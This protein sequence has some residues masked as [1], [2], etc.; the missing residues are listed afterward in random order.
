MDLKL[1][2]M[3]IKEKETSRQMQTNDVANTKAQIRYDGVVKIR[4]CVRIVRR[5]HRGS[6]RE[7]FGAYTCN[8]NK[9]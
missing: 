1:M 8:T 9:I 4:H 7:G 3:V 5:N 2:Q 6:G